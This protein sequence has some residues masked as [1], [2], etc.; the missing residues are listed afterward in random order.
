MEGCRAGRGEYSGCSDL[1]SLWSSEPELSVGN[2]S[3]YSLLAARHDSCKGMSSPL[4][5]ACKQ[6]KGLHQ[7]LGQGA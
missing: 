6:K 1:P 3:H 5:G 7:H 4:S 2:W